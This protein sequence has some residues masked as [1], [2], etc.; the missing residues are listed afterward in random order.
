[1]GEIIYND[2]VNIKCKVTFI[3]Y[4]LTS[5]VN[6]LPNDSVPVSHS[7]ALSSTVLS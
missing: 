4:V 6:A 7:S 1:M 3:Y 5:T 2:F